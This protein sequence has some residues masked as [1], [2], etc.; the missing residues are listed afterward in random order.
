MILTPE[1]II[2]DPTNMV[3]WVR[4]AIEAEDGVR[5]H[6][7]LAAGRNFLM[8]HYR[9]TNGQQIT[10]DHEVRWLEMALDEFRREAPQIEEGRV[11]YHVYAHTPE[12]QQNLISFL[13]QIVP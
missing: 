3:R 11:Y 13:S 2:I 12:S 10:Q 9:I 7:L 8:D 5:A 1:P 6:L 4:V